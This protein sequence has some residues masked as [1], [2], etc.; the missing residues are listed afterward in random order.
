M[1]SGLADLANDALTSVSADATVQ[2]EISGGAKLSLDLSA[3]SITSLAQGGTGAVVQAVTDELV[4]LG[5]KLATEALGSALEGLGA[6]SNIAPLVGQLVSM[7]I[8]IVDAVENHSARGVGRSVAEQTDYWSRDV[9]HGGWIEPVVATAATGPVPADYFVNGLNGV[10]PDGS[11]RYNFTSLGWLLIYATETTGEKDEAKHFGGSVGLPRERRALYGKLRR[12]ICACRNN[13][14]LGQPHSAPASDGGV[15]LWTAYVDML[16][17]DVEKG[18]LTPALVQYLCV[19]RGAAIYE[20]SGP[21]DARPWAGYAQDE[22]D[23]GQTDRDVARSLAQHGMAPARERARG[24]IEDHGYFSPQALWMNADD[25][26]LFGFV[27]E[28][29]LTLDP[30]YSQF[31]RL[32]DSARAALEQ[33]L[34]ARGS[35]ARVQLTGALRALPGRSKSSRGRKLFGWGLAALVGTKLAGW[36]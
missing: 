7:G 36:W 12:A 30:F 28:W 5:M 18:R 11:P 6:A 23:F 2:V 34:R 4:G 1:T 32:E 24:A 16:R 13:S 10:S 21:T 8:A 19:L 3:A 26:P 29:Q 14:P 20:A 27:R 17:A 25:H 9:Q 35:P 33:L 15:S 22:G 31:D